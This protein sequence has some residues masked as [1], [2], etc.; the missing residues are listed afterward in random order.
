[1]DCLENGCNGYRD[2]PCPGQLSPVLT[3]SSFNAMEAVQA[4]AHN[5]ITDT[6]YGKLTKDETVP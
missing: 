1:M 6:P 2:V 4:P 3:Q 5:S